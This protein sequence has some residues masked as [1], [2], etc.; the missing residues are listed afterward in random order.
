MTANERHNE[1]VKARATF[2]N[3]LAI[4]T[5]IAGGLNALGE[6]RYGVAL[7]FT[8]AGLIL[9]YGALKVLETLKVTLD[10]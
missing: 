1:I 9:H 6:N 8:L 7:A 4:G 5:I 3:A 10:E 2:A